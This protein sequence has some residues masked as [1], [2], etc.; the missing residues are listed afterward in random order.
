MP[1]LDDLLA[2]SMLFTSAGKDA[3]FELT[4][5]FSVPQPNPKTEDLDEAKIRNNPVWQWKCEPA[6]PGTWR[7]VNCWNRGMAMNYSMPAPVCDVVQWRDVKVVRENKTEVLLPLHDTFVIGAWRIL[8]GRIHEGR[9]SLWPLDARADASSLVALAYQLDGGKVTAL[10]REQCDDL[11]DALIPP[12][13][14]PPRRLEFIAGPGAADAW[15]SVG[16]SRYVLL[17]ELV[18]IKENDD[19]APKG[20]V[21]MCRLHPHAMLWSNEPLESFE[22][23]LIMQRPAKA[24]THGDP[25]MHEEI[26]ALVVSD[27]NDPDT[28]PIKPPDPTADTLYDYYVTDAFTEFEGRARDNAFDHPRQRTSEVCLADPRHTRRRPVEGGVVRNAG[29]SPWRD[30]PEKE[31]RQGQ[32]D[33]VHLAPRMRARFDT[34]VSTH[35]GRRSV[36]VS[37]DEIVMMFVCLHDCLH[38]HVRWGTHADEPFTRGWFG[39]RPHAKAGAPTVPENQV[40]FVKFPKPHML[41]YRAVAEDVKAGAMQVLCHHGFGY[42]VDQWPTVA[43]D[44]LRYAMRSA[45]ELLAEAKKEPFYTE[46]PFDVV[47]SAQAWA[48]F[49][50]RFRFGGKRGA[51]PVE[52]LQVED[53]ER[54]M[55]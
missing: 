40:V 38:M 44:G 17:V 29:S 49:Y 30:H 12:A 50:W 1:S 53:V 18:C 24:M 16:P 54:C 3:A 43:A 33:N 28:V 52:R 22:A 42:A 34:I 8:N 55:R 36:P 20:L 13:D 2:H 10:T 23:T 5:A 45:V 47:G 4:G 25:T 35:E 11:G 39:G 46:M 37:L 9:S 31:T 15:V 26:G 32:F 41:E 51:R 14:L 21:G 7:E 19:F 6:A 48:T 27:R